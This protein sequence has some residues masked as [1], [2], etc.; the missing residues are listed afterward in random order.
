MCGYQS[1]GLA[2][3]SKTILNVELDKNWTII[4]SDWE[5]PVLSSEQI[6]YAAKDAH[7]AIEIFKI[8]ADRLIPE[9]LFGSKLEHCQN[10]LNYYCSKFF[11]IQ[12][13]S[14]SGSGKDVYS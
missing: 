13:N 6:D 5:T 8:L 2:K 3:L 9:P 11:D 4:C 1:G 14:T 7:V 12:Y 10:I